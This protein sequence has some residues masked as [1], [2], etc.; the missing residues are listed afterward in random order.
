MCAMTVHNTPLWVLLIGCSLVGAIAS[1][2]AELRSMDRR[3][4]AVERYV[5]AALTG[6]GWGMCAATLVFFAAALIVR[7]EG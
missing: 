3:L 6:V 1:L 5:V 7:L 2:R 4:P